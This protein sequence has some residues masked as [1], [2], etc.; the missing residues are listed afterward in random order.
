MF[1]CNSE[2]YVRLITYWNFS[3]PHSGVRIGS[4]LASGRAPPTPPWDPT[5]TNRAQRDETA[6]HFP[7][8]GVLSA[9][10]SGNTVSSRLPLKDRS[11]GHEEEHV[12]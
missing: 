1:V 10:R 12:P 5:D 2:N 9:Q 6:S 7:R 8:L 3:F 11:S 4:H